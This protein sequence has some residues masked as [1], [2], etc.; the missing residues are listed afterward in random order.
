MR[1][2]GVVGW[3]RCYWQSD[4]GWLACLGAAEEVEGVWASGC[5]E[6]AVAEVV[7]VGARAIPLWCHSQ[8]CG[9]GCR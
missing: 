2:T 9:P 8:S 7:E 6:E 1:K 4:S 3:W 5:L